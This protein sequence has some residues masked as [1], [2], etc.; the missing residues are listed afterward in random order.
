MALVRSITITTTIAEQGKEAGAVTGHTVEAC[1]EVGGEERV[2]DVSGVNPTLTAL[3]EQL[4][5]AVH[6]ETLQE[7]RP[8]MQR[9]VD[10]EKAFER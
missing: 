8:A 6:Q 3:V 2:Y 4:V 5:R 9:V 1:V 10:A 7:S